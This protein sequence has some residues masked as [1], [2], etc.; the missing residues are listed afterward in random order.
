MMKEHEN[1]LSPET[2]NTSG[3]IW[4]D[5]IS[6]QDRYLVQRLRTLS[7]EYVQENEQALDRIWSR[8]AQSQKHSV[9]LPL[10]RRAHENTLFPLN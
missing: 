3:E 10:R 9:S 2:S 4:P 7:W 8:L 1:E 6:S 5:E